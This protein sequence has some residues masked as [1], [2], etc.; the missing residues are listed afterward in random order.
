MRKLIS[1]LEQPTFVAYCSIAAII[2]IIVPLFFIP[3]AGSGGKSYL[4]RTHLVGF[5][6]SWC[7][8]GQQIPYSRT[9]YRIQSILS[10]ATYGLC[11]NYN[12]YNWFCYYC[13]GL[14]HENKA[15][16]TN[17]YNNNS[18]NN[19]C[20]TSAIPLAAEFFLDF[21][22]Q[23]PVQLCCISIKRA[24]SPYKY[25]KI[26]CTG[27]IFGC[28]AERTNPHIDDDDS[29]FDSFSFLSWTQ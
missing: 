9:L 7:C 15:F 1:L 14:I 8:V 4:L 23:V 24:C 26:M 2:A 10:F 16:N 6:H 25:S 22:S 18:L 3:K 12:Y 19:S 13:Y 11:Y 5:D 27:D 28:P 20:I 29:F 21:Y 17:N